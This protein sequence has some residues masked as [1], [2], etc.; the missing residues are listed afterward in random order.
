LRC[1]RSQLALMKLLSSFSIFPDPVRQ[2]EV[3]RLEGVLGSLARHYSGHRSPSPIS[4]KLV[5]ISPPAPRAEVQRSLAPSIQALLNV[6]V[7][8][9][10]LAPGAGLRR[11]AGPGRTV[12]RPRPGDPRIVSHHNGPLAIPQSHVGYR[13]VAWRPPFGGGGGAWRVGLEPGKHSVRVGFSMI[14]G[15]QTRA[16]TR[17]LRAGRSRP[18]GDRRPRPGHS[19]LSR[20]LSVIAARNPCGGHFAE[21]AALAR[22]R[23]RRTTRRAVV[24]PAVGTHRPSIFDVPAVSPAGS[25][26]CR[27]PPRG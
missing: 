5:S 19:P 10:V 12:S 9:A 20:P 8:T 22:R 26:L 6:I 25:S 14:A 1:W 16:A 15:V 21:L 13:D 2:W 23:W 3:A 11:R 7:R 4:C 27:R 24:G 18:A 17:A